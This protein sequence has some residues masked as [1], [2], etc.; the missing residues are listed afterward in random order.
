[1][2]RYSAS[3]IKGD[4]NFA[5]QNLKTKKGILI[6]DPA[7]C[8]LKNILQRG[9]PTKISKFLQEH[10]HCESGVISSP[11]YFNSSD[12]QEWFETIKGDEETSYNPAYYFFYSLLPNDLS[13]YK[14]IQNLIIPECD[15]LMITGEKGTSFVNRAVDFYLPQA[16]L[17]IEIDGSQHGLYGGR[18]I[19]ETR[20]NY[21]QKYG[22]ITV[23]IST[24]EIE[25][26]NSQ[27]KNKM[28]MIKHQL[29]LHMKTLLPY[30]LAFERFPIDDLVKAVAVMRWQLTILSMV[31]NGLLNINDSEWDFQVKD[32]EG[33]KVLDLAIKDIFLWLRHLNK[34]LK[35]PFSPPHVQISYVK[36]FTPTK[37]I[38]VD[39]SLRKRWTDENKLME[40]VIFVRGD[41]FYDHD[42]FSISVEDPVNYSI[43]SDGEEDDT[44]SLHFLLENIFGHRVFQ[45]GQLPI[46]INILTGRDTV[47]LLPTGGGK[48]LCYQFAAFLQPSISFVVV[49]II[50]LMRDQVENLRNASITRI[51][52]VSSDQE[53]IEKKKVQADFSNGKYLFILIS[54]ERFQVPDF[55]DYLE[56]LNK[57]QTIALAIID[58]V[59][60][61]SEWGH[62]F[63]ISYLHL[64]KTIRHYCPTVRLLGL[65]ATAS[66]NVLNDILIE[67]QTDKSNV[68]TLLEYTRPE[69]N[70]KVFILSE[71]DA[72]KKFEY[73]TSIIN[74]LNKKAGVLETNDKYANPGI[75]FT[76]N[77]NGKK[78]CYELSNQL[79]RTYQTKIPFYSGEKPKNEM[80]T[81]QK[82]TEYKKVVQDSFKQDEVPIL[83]ATKAFGMGV[84]KSN[85]RYTI[86]YSLPGSLEAFYQEAGRAGRD[87]NRATNFVLFSRDKINDEEYNKLFQLDTTIEEIDITLKAVG[88]KRQG[89]ILS[90]F[91]LWIQN[92]QGVDKETNIIKKVFNVYAER[93]KTKIV[94][95][96]YL[97][98][99]FN[100]T[101]KAIYRLSILG[102]VKDWTVNS[103]GDYGSFEVTFEYF[104][105]ETPLNQ[106]F[107]Y[108]KK[109]D[110]SFSLDDNLN[111]NYQ[112]YVKVYENNELETY[113]RIFQILVQ[114]TYDN[115][116]YNRRQSLKTLVDL[117]MKYHDNSLKL[118]QS[119]ESYFKFTDTVYVLDHIAQNP[120]EYHKWFQVFYDEDGKVNEYTSIGSIKSSLIRFLENYRFNTG[121]NYLSGM[122]ELLTDD[123][124]KVDG[125]DRL[126]SA[127]NNIKS[128]ELAYQQDILDKTLK[129][130]VYLSQKNR[131]HL[132]KILCHFYND[133]ILTIYN[134]FDD[135][136][137]MD[138]YLQDAN[139][140]L[141][142]IGDRFNGKLKSIK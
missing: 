47:G 15:I 127:F 68:K 46:I 97:M 78:G 31:E 134:S 14:F 111:Y 79:T 62:D 120:G 6:K 124:S 10:L 114:W 24:P 93:G 138:L 99:N 8:I 108:I 38:K 5:I 82:F 74:S 32:L 33:T 112:R 136:H 34:L 67:F 119:I 13:E 91:F 53:A 139:K 103:W 105:Y 107:E 76:L 125:E 115:I 86:H 88:Y 4:T 45:N 81:P 141:K 42:Y 59:H 43:I 116:F 25:S 118:K 2:I 21:L 44:P 49:P 94:S 55:R 131:N 37:S 102:I 142:E 123:F 83:I 7:I 106:L 140:R 77:V 122:L 58:E 18:E 51:N 70:F 69:L 39:F 19:D 73:L 57:D 80:I 87:K 3:Y 72:Q 100:E 50:S 60:C 92:N 133:Q 20:N 64:C 17:V 22:I 36:K 135:E 63:R 12:P 113:E 130:G 48:S 84:D 23:R 28:R 110:Q 27:Y 95:C 121:L 132:S 101:Q 71:V 117:C 129:L 75:I 9:N 11:L 30:K 56:K 54:P 40:E 1:M 89:D 29:D 66:I 65:S 126:V 98:L 41:Y 61:L 85:I 35:K 104:N 96:Q 128:F 90:N 16:K 26:R 109:Y 52:Y 137:S